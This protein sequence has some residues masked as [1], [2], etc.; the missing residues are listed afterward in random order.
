MKDLQAVIADEPELRTLLASRALTSAERAESLRRIFENHV[1]D[2]LLRFMLVVNA[3]HR[4]SGLEVILETAAELY[5]QRQGIMNL[6]A[7]VAGDVDTHQ[8]ADRLGDALGKQVNLATHRDES[9][10]GGLKIRVG[11]R[12][13]DGS[14]ATQLTS[15]RRKMVEAGRE[16]AREQAA[17]AGPVEMPT[18]EELTK[19]SNESDESNENESS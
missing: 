9:L 2:L 3:K 8:L 13:I 6:E 15:L 11:D 14:V 1:H 12:I 19:Q 4:L 18:A 5:D 10:I 7:W 17:A 16:H